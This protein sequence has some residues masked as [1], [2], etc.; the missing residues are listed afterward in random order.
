MNEGLVHRFPRKE[1]K[2]FIKIECPVEIG[3]K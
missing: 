1:I 2:E 3:K